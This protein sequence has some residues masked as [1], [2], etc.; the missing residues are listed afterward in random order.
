MKVAV[1]G[2]GWWGKQIVRSLQPSARFQVVAA[3]DPFQTPETDAFVEDHGIAFAKD[4]DTILAR[5]D[6]EGVILA[7]PHSLHEEQVLAVL[8][9]SKEVFCEKP[10]AMSSVGA[11]RMLDAA[12]RHGK[13]LGIGHERRFEPAIAEM[14]RMV[15]QG[16]LG[17]LLHVEANVSHDLFRKLDPSNWRLDQKD[18][19]AGMMTAVGI[20]LTDIFIALA[21]PAESVR[22]VTDSMIF[23]P[24]AQDYMSATI[25]FRSGVRGTAT[26]ISVTPFHGRLAVFGDKGW[27]ELV[28]EGNVDEGLPTILTHRSKTAAP[29][30]RRVYPATEAVLANFESWCDAVEKGTPYPFS[31]E[32]LLENIK[33]FEAIVQSGRNDGARVVL[34]QSAG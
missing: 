6:V 25:T 29:W 15:R 17:R 12:A 34:E 4:L 30:Q 1:A 20:H 21:G 33:L 5:G 27:V 19:P 8:A 26:L 10:L 14:M 18:A 22:C 28:S 32:E 13:V 11:K 31:P 3:M 24:P 9:A 2:M 23:A 7:T 16:E